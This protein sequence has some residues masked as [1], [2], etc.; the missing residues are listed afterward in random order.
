MQ[1]AA[2]EGSDLTLVDDNF[3]S[4]DVRV[5]SLEQL[6]LAEFIG[7]KSRQKVYK[8]AIKMLDG[9]GSIWY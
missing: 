3:T 8:M 6:R 9:F 5:T 2:N 7:K 1:V 4:V